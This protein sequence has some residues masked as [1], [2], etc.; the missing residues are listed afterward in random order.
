[1]KPSRPSRGPEA[2]YVDAL[3]L[4]RPAWVPV[5]LARAALGV[6]SV[7][8]VSLA[9]EGLGSVALLSPAEAS[10]LL[11]GRN[12]ARGAARIAGTATPG[13]AWGVALADGESTV[14]PIAMAAMFEGVA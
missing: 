11:K 6:A 1:M 3:H 13:S 4:H 8:V 5:F 14:W 10:A 12:D 9:P 2:P 7:V